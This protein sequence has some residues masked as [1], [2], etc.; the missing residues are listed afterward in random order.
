MIPPLDR[1]G[2]LRLARE[3]GCERYSSMQPHV[4]EAL[5][6]FAALVAQHEGRQIAELECAAGRMREVLQQVARSAVDEWIEDA[7]NSVFWDNLPITVVHKIFSAG[8]KAAVEAAIKISK[9]KL[10]RKQI[11][12]LAQKTAD[13]F[14]HYTKGWH[15]SD[16]SLEQFATLIASQVSDLLKP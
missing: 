11:I 12:E 4:V 16:D 8:W 1:E 9:E 13:A 2:V 10:D 7:P 15:F 14:D 5:E 6:R 3:A